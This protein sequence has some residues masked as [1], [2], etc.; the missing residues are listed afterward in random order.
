VNECGRVVALSVVVGKVE[1]RD[2]SGRN[3]F[4]VFRRG[5]IGLRGSYEGVVSGDTGNNCY[6]YVA[7]VGDASSSSE[8]TP[9]A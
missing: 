3:C 4:G 7:G 1:V 2:R 9:F 8:M 5:N 6:S